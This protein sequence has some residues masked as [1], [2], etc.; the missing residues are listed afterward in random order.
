VRKIIAWS[1]ERPKTVLFGWLVLAAIAVP[2]AI[3]LTGALV[4]GGFNAPNGEAA[5]AEATLVKAFHQPP[6]TQLVVL[7]DASGPAGSAV[8]V[9]AAAASRQP[10]VSSVVDYRTQPS[11]LSKDGH[12][13]FLEVGF[14]SSDTDVEK[15]TPALQT[16]VAAAVGPNV[17]A[18]VT[19]QP[20]LYYQLNK[21][22]SKD[23]TRA[24]LIAFPVLFIV[25]LLV[26]RS[27]AAMIV[28]LILAGVTLG[29]AEGAGYGFA[30]LTDVNSLYENIV[31]M[32]GLAVSI[33]Y[34]LFIIKR[35]REELAAGA[36]VKQALERT[37]RTVGHSVLISALAVITALCS[38]FIPGAM[39]FTSIALGGVT[40][41]V[42][43]GAIVLT[44][45]PA[46]LV[47]LGHRI[48][49]GS[50]GRKQLPQPAP[51]T[52]L[53][54]D[55]VTTGGFARSLLARPALTLIVLVAGF[56]ALAYPASRLIWQ[57]PVGS[58]S[59]L[60]AGDSARVGLDR[61]DHSIGLQSLFPS[62]V[63]LTAPANDSAA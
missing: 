20:A 19:G 43:A 18:D 28:P 45:L 58:A 63:V 10:G 37:M 56:A 16:A 9:A 49:W 33:D 52:R 42:I 1:L 62:Q 13:T 36:E 4:P 57:V 61:V 53:A 47:L 22:A 25:L 39:S 50:I 30:H 12:T 34:S 51:G 23:A 48:N 27:V 59:I 31:S 32:I 26:F 5:K 14:T 8:P 60:P 24:E 55:Q 40:V 21:E 29:L 3:Q 54:A 2:F 46:V 41:A 35:H 17:Q 11:W 15:N 6:D 44:L 7:Y 38:L